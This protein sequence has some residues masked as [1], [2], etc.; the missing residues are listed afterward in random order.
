MSIGGRVFAFFVSVTGA[1]L[2]TRLVRAQ[3]A[4]PAAAVVPFLTDTANGRSGRPQSRDTYLPTCSPIFCPPCSPTTLPAANPPSSL[5]IRHLVRHSPPPHLF[6]QPLH[7]PLLLSPSSPSSPLTP[8]RFLAHH[9]NSLASLPLNILRASLLLA[10]L[11]TRLLS[12]SPSLVSI[13]TGHL[14]SSSHE[15]VA[16]S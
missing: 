6:T 8:T 15:L 9:S 11:R 14:L 13:G 7:P 3:P 5:T 1:T 4:Q 2:S 10:Y 12:T 16:C